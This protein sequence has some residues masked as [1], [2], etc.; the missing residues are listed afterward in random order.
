MNESKALAIVPSSMGEIQSMAEI[1]AKSSLL[2][3]ALRGKVP[4]VVVQILAGAELGLPPMASIRGVHIVA[5]KP[6]LAADTMVALVRKSGSCEYFMVESETETAV[7]YVCKRIGDPKEQRY[8]WSDEDTKL[9]GLNTKDNWRLHKKQMRR[10]R[11]KAIL[12]RDVWPDVLA[13]VYDGDSGELAPPTASPITHRDT[14]PANDDVI[15]AEIVED[16]L[17]ELVKTAPTAAALEALKPK[18]KVLGA[19][20]RRTLVTEAY[21]ARQKHF[22]SM[23]KAATAVE[24]L[25][26]EPAA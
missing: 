22:E 12:A 26:A 7:T 19:S 18:C 11:C 10:A 4:D 21:L 5:G 3:D 15:D 16:D 23:A 6:I 13:G 17:L 24:K 8:T 25:A 2:P 9:A 20:P 14:K 1:L